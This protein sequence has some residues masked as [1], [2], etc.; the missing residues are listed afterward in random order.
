MPGLERPLNNINTTRS[1]AISF[2][3][4]RYLPADFKQSLMALRPSQYR[5]RRRT[6]TIRSCDISL[7]LTTTNPLHCLAALKLRHLGGRPNRTPRDIALLRRPS[8]LDLIKWR[9]NV[10]MP[11]SN[12]IINSPCGVVV[13]AQLSTSGLKPTPLCDSSW[14]MFKTSRVDL[15]NRSSRVTIRTSPACSVFIASASALR[16]V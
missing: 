6:D 4:S 14:K 7:H 16:S 1:A 15:A 13:S 10:A 11:A 3:G 5:N 8:V 9:S 12:V 2:S